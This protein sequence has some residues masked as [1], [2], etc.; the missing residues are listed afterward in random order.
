M[1]PVATDVG[2]L[3][4]LASLLLDVAETSLNQTPAL[5]PDLSYVSPGAPPIQCCPVLTVHVQSLSEGSTSPLAPAPA[6]G[7][8]TSFQRINLAGLVVTVMRCG[9]QIQKDGSV[10]AAD[11]QDVAEQVAADGWALWNGLRFAIEEGAFLDKCS[12]IHVDQGQAVAEQGGC[13]G[14]LFRLRA[15]IGGM[16]GWGTT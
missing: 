15:E 14:W 2:S 10:L 6:T 1:V 12:V 16:P 9:P 11:A 3:F 13:V 4:D 7:R 8:R 5:A